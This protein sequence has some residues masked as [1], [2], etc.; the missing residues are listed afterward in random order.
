MTNIID[1]L[2]GLAI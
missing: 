2:T 1:Q